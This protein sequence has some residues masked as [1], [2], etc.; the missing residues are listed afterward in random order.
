MMRT[1]TIKELTERKTKSEV[2]HLLVD[3][4]LYMS[5]AMEGFPV[6]G[7]MIQKT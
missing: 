3:C 7:A 6:A 1:A 5:S 4:S 2:R